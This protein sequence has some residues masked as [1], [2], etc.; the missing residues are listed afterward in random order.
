MDPVALRD[1]LVEQAISVAFVATPLAE[2]MLDLPWP[3]HTRLR[4]LLTGADTLHRR[5]SPGLPF[6]V[7]NNYGPTE[8]TVVATS[9]VVTAGGEGL[10]SIG[11]AISNTLVRILDEAR[12]PVP[13]G[14]EGELWVGGAGVARGYRRQPQL[15]AE[16][17]VPDP[18]GPPDGRLYRTG[19]RA[20][21]LSDGS[22]AFC[23]RSD[24]QVKIRG[25]RVELD[26]IVAALNAHPMIAASAV[27]AVEGPA[28]ERGLIA[29]VVPRGTMPS[30]G[31]LVTTLRER[32]PEYMRPAAF[33]ELGELPLT[34]SGKVDRARLPKPEAAGGGSAPGFVAPAT[35]VEQRLAAMVAGLLGVPRVGLSDDF[36][37]MGGHSLLGTQLIARVRDTF[38]VE[39]PLRT[40]FDHPTVGALA[41]QIE[42]AIFT[43]LEAA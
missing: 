31:D 30:P 23:G 20:R 19:D 1:W 38:D 39:L 22:L 42:H 37:L 35:A 21:T 11:K 32:L 43:R 40:I 3:A 36:F 41:A 33:V 17:F 10:P 16:R 2:R 15:T 8:C 27:I 18:F 5:P 6:T 13:D 25:H 9:G 7:V 28:H 12:Q 34:A 29:Y 14:T 4:T 24:D 26:E